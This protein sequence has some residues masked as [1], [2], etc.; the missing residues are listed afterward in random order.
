MVILV[1]G[2][3]HSAQAVVA[4]GQDIGD[5]KLLQARSAGRLD[6]ADIGDVVAGHGVE[7]QAQGVGVIA[8][9]VSLQ[10]AVGH[11]ALG[12]LLFGGSAA[13]LLG[14]FLGAG[15]DR[16]AVDQVDAVLIQFDHSRYFLSKTGWYV[17]SLSSRGGDSF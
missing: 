9:V 12:G 2:A 8:L 11:G 10:D 1:D 3:A 17:Y 5:G 16:F 4:I 7:L 13:G 14:R 15:A 6:D